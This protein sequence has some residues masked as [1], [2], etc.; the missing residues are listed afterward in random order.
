MVWKLI[1]KL[2]RW[3]ALTLIVYVPAAKV[4]AWLTVPK[5]W[6]K[7][8]CVP[9]GALGLPEVNSL[10]LPAT[11]EPLRKLH[12]DP[13]GLYWYAPEP[14]PTWGS[15]NPGSLGASTGLTRT[16]SRKTVLSWPSGS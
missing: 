9:S 5:Y 8:T 16:W 11:P 6:T 13:L 1:W 2:A 3:A 12:G 10:P 4:T 14:V 7:A 15:S